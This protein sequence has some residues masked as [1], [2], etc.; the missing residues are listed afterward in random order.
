MLSQQT[1]YLVVSRP[2][3]WR[4]Q[5]RC[6]DSHDMARRHIDYIQLK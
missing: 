2:T 6:S 3:L 4:Q 1:K 5:F